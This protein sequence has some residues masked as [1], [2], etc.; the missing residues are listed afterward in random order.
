MDLTKVNQDFLLFTKYL[1]RF[2]HQNPVF[3]RRN[4]FQGQALHGSELRDIVWFYHKGEE[5]TEE[6]WKDEV[7]KAISIFLN[8]AAELWN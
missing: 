3:R 2:R 8:I 4:W 7:V 1:I 5:M 6:Q